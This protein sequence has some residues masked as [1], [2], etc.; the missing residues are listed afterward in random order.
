M[1]LKETFFNLLLNFTDKKSLKIALWNEIEQNYSD[2]KR[3]YH[4]LS[5]L[6]NLLNQLIEVKDKIESWET[7]LFTLFYHDILYNVLKSDNEEQSAKL[8]KRMKQINVPSQIIEN[9]KSQILATK[10]HL[11]N[12]NS[13]INH[14]ID[15]DLS[16]LGQNLETYTT[17][18]NNVR[19][20]YSLYP[21]LIYNPG[22]K[23][24]LKHF[25]E[26][27]KIFKTDYFYSKFEN[28]AKL[29]LQTELEQL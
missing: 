26:M 27:A 11:E 6:D 2:K 18:F 12:S 14:F 9:C 29:N 4:T 17:Y 19:K 5:H 13:D 1:V 22:R 8:A 3:Y 23:K 21:K 20:E 28:Q 24:V 10:N 15:A 7:V 16:I 25:L